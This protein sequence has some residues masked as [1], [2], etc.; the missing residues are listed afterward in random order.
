MRL[1]GVTL[2]LGVLLALVASGAPAA[3]PPD[4]CA[5]CHLGTGD[6]RLAEPAKDFRDDIHA[7]KGLGCVACHGGDSK[8]EGMEAMDPQKGYIGKTGSRQIPARSGPC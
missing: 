3:P 1:A 2:A 7:A 5:A 8:E 6:G 4:K